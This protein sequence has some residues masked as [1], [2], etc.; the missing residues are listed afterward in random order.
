MSKGAIGPS[1]L[2]IGAVLELGS[3]LKSAVF[4]GKLLTV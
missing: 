4:A 1:K 3:W 2:L